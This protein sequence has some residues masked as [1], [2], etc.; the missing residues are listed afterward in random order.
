L[1]ISSISRDF[2]TLKIC[3]KAK[4]GILQP[5]LKTAAGEREVDL[6]PELAKMLECFLSGR[7]SGLLFATASGR[8]LLQSNTLQDSLH[9][10]LRKLSLPKGGFNMFRRFRLTHVAKTECPEFLRHFW[11]GHA[12]KHVSERYIKLLH[13]REWRLGWAE[14]IGMGFDVRTTPHS[15]DIRE[16]RI[17]NEPRGIHLVA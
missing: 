12:A 15:S 5:Y 1:D 14:R 9:P 17:Q 4:R 8:Q 6:C 3:Q 13:D 16:S 7:R 2:R 11:S 10:I